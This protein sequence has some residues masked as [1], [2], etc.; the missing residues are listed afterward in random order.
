MKYEL[1]KVLGQKKLC[2]LLALVVVLNAILFY[3]HCT[4]NSKGYALGDLR[5]AY[6]RADTLEQ[7]D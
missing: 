3:G 1:S 5:E 2:L 6:S 7:E 4:D